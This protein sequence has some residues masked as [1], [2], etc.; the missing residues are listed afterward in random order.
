MVPPRPQGRA[1]GRAT[2]RMADIFNEVQEDLRRERLKQLW[3]RY[4]GLLIGLAALVVIGVGAWRGYEYYQTRAAEQAGDRYEAA[5]K[6]AAD[7]KSDEARAAFATLAADG[8]A[9]YALL[10]KLREADEVAKSDQKAALK[11]Y[12]DIANGTGD[13]MLRDAARIRGAYIAA[14]IG[15]LD[16]VRRLA[17][18]LAAGGPWS[19]LARET[20]GLAAYKAG[21]TAEARRQ[22]EAV[23]SQADAP[24]SVRQ[25]A[26]LLLAVLPPAEAE[27]GKPAEPARPTD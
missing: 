2:D 23:V 6:L 16:D 11:L 7:G 9:G 14:D 10:A 13:E 25:R 12:E 1:A 24:G 15:T 8:P 4:G 18:R 21:D 26:D 17:E 27:P 19:A 5:S 20:M 3:D 22:F